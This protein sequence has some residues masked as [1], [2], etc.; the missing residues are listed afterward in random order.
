ML[1]ITKHL[2]NTIKKFNDIIVS[3]GK[4]SWVWDINNIKYLDFTGGIG[5][6]S[7]GHSH[8]RIVKTI[9]NQSNKMIL[10][11]QNVFLS[12]EPQINLTKQLLDIMPDHLNNFFYVNSGSEATDNAIK[13]ARQYTK[14]QNIITLNKGFHG[15]TLG[16]MS[17]T[18]SNVNYR[19][20]CN[21]LLP[22]VFFCNYLNSN[23]LDEIFKYQSDYDETAAIIVEPI[24]G[25]GG[26]NYINNKFL[27]HIETICKE[28]NIM[29]IV[30]EVQTG[31]GRTGKWWA[32]EYSDVKPDIMTFAKGIASGYPFAGVVA[33]D[34]IMNSLTNSLLGGTYGGNPLGCS[35]ATETISII[36]DENLIDNANFQGNK[37]K[38]YLSDLSYIKNV[39]QHGL[40]IGI[41]LYYND[42]IK[43][44]L[45]INRLKNKGILVL[46]AGSNSIRILPPLNVT[47]KEVDIFLKTF[48]KLI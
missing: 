30:D 14:K 8:P 36:K 40:M 45:L 1:N 25:E 12:H 42:D 44:N 37:I 46:L 41:D 39:R 29:F 2:P 33:N 24:Q 4:G 16:A 47:N 20:Q 21:S 15:R 6:L 11:Q 34:K 5:A 31:V 23:N 7:T 35:I 43:I 10:A 17:V 28:N 3:K 22:G 9:Q 26:I 13:I 27:K 18:S 32:H 19:K 48:S 38:K